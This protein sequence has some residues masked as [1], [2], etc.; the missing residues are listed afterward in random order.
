[1]FTLFLY[2]FIENLKLSQK[3]A[4]HLQSLQIPLV[5]LYEL[6]MMRIFKRVEYKSLA[7]QKLSKVEILC[8]VFF[9]FTLGYVSYCGRDF[10]FFFWNINILI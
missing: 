6:Y 4:F 7:K 8:V 5:L 9:L 1:M 2:I 10:F 3:S